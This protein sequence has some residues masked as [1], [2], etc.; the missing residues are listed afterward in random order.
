MVQPGQTHPLFIVKLKPLPKD[1]I[2][3]AIAVDY[4]NT[5]S[6]LEVESHPIDSVDFLNAALQHHLK[7]A[8]PLCVYFEGATQNY[9]P[10]SGAG[11]L[12]QGDLTSTSCGFQR[13]LVLFL[14]SF[15]FSFSSF[16]NPILSIGNKDCAHY[17]CPD[18]SE[19]AATHTS[20]AHTTHSCCSCCHWRWWH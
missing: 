7:T 18:G 15:S 3:R 12:N 14:F 19:K 16:D 9:S 20:T 11:V 4:E 1:G 17:S 5:S 6:V 10:L 2:P 8:D 13:C